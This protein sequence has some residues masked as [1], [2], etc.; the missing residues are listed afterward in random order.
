MQRLLLQED[1]TCLHQW[2]GSGVVKCLYDSQLHGCHCTNWTRDFHSSHPN[3]H[4]SYSWSADKWLWPHSPLYLSLNHLCLQN[5][6][7]DLPIEEPTSPVLRRR[8]NEDCQQQ[9]FLP[10]GSPSQD[11]SF[12]LWCPFPCSPVLQPSPSMSPAPSQY[13]ICRDSSTSREAVCEISATDTAITVEST[14]N[15]QKATNQHSPLPQ[16]EAMPLPGDDM[17][18]CWLHTQEGLLSDHAVMWGRRCRDGSK[19][20]KTKAGQCS[21]SAVKHISIR[22]AARGKS[23][24]C[25][26][27]M[28]QFVM[29]V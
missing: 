12:S 20:T 24:V 10:I 18:H 1:Y 21:M 29:G 25:R 6:S 17:D 8:R 5:S 16:A 27:L 4:S 23:T 26:T 2:F 14:G 11:M 19:Q 9:G 7:T 28:E 22:S 3:S 15:L 13:L